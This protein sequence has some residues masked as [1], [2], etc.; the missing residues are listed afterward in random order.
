MI[1]KVRQSEE[2]EEKVT[3]SPI[4]SDS[5]NCAL[6][7]QQWTHICPCKNKNKQ[8]NC[9]ELK[10]LP[11]CSSRGSLDFTEHIVKWG[12]LSDKAWRGYSV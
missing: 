2:C 1:T 6:I 8:Q 7:V 11:S 12:R 9:C 4:E 10:S 3:D 5:V